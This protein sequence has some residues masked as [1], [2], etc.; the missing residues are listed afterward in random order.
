M[1]ASKARPTECFVLSADHLDALFSSLKERGYS[2]VGPTVRDGAI[3][4][5]VIESVKDLPV[6]IRDSQSAGYYRLMKRDDGAFFG[7]TSPS[8]NLKR[9]LYPPT[10]RL[11]KVY[12][13][14]LR[15]EPE[16]LRGEKLALIGVRPCDLQ[17][18]K[19]LD[20]VLL[21]GKFKDPYYLSQRKKIF[22]LAVNCSEP[23]ETCFCTSM[24]SGPKAGSGYDLALTEIVTCDR[25]FFIVQVGSDE[26]RKVLEK[27]PCKEADENEIAAAE[28]MLE[29]AS[30]RMGRRLE[31]G[32]LREILYD[33]LESDRWLEIGKKCLSCGNCTLVCPTCFC[34][35]TIDKTDLRGEVAERWRLWDSCFTEEHSYIHGGTIRSQR[36]SRYRQWLIHKLAYWI[37]QFGVSGCV[38]CGRCITWCPVGIDLIEEANALREASLERSK[39]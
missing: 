28:I 35:T 13:E 14:R 38:G 37:D 27:V 26:G 19:V 1:A 32:D 23:G 20:R 29:N 18:I 15:F 30:R 17:A 16:P 31:M 21:A 2:L 7:F 3:I 9:F 22:I 24:K 25:H 4:Y 8:N 6:G 5:D 34:T 12:R 36:H 33:A 10:L 11:F 39:R